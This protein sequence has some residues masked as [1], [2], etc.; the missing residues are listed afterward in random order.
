MLLRR[1]SLILRHQLLLLL[2][3]VVVM[4][5]HRVL[6]AASQSVQLARRPRPGLL[7]FLC[8]GPQQLAEYRL[9]PPC[10]PY[11]VIIRALGS[12]DVIADVIDA[13]RI[14][15]LAAPPVPRHDVIGHVPPSCD[16][17]FAT[18]TR[19]PRVA[20]V[21]GGGVRLPP[22]LLLLEKTTNSITT[23]ITVVVVV[24]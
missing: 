16:D 20:R 13:E 7:L 19:R 6:I 5:I 21:G 15:R 1:A 24:V 14:R 9:L 12:R 10:R 2:L 22:L 11:V 8:L 23:V 17:V 3:V 4:M 18:T